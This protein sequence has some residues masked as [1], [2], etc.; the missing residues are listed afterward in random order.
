MRPK[1]AM[2]IESCGIRQYVQASQRLA[3]SPAAGFI[4]RGNKG[5]E[6]DCIQLDFMD[7]GILLKKYK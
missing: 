6:G 4:V 5:F 3:F 1:D 2:A 7:S